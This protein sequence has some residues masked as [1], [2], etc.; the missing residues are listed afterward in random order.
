LAAEEFAGRLF[1]RERPKDVLEMLSEDALPGEIIYIKA[2]R[3]DR[4]ARVFIP[5]RYK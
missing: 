4:L 5:G 2:T 3:V 1:V